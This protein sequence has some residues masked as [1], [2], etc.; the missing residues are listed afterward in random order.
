MPHRIKVVCSAL[1]HHRR[2]PDPIGR[3]S[4][5]DVVDHEVLAGL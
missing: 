4:N 2:R 1:T 3:G 5:Q